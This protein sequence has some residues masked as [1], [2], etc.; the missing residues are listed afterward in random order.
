MLLVGCALAV[1]LA[2]GGLVGD[3]L[4]ER[5]PPRP[6]VVAPALAGTAS[7]ST[8]SAVARL[9]AAVRSEPGNTTLLAQLGLAY[10]QRWRET[11]DAS[12][13]PRSEAAL[14]RAVA[15]R[16]DEPD[17]VLGLGSLA[18]IRHEF[19][20]ALGFGRTAGTL[21]PGSDR[22]Y[23]VVGDALV[24]LGRYDQ[25]F[26][27]FERMAA[28]RP[29]VAS[30]TRV[31]YAREL[32]GDRAGALQAL[33]LALDAA[34]GQREQT[35][36]VLVEIAKLEAPLG[37]PRAA[38]LAV[39]AA[40]L[41]FPGYPSARLQAVKLDLRDGRPA[42]ALAEARRLADAAPSSESVT[43][44]ADLLERVG[45]SAEARRQRATAAVIDRLLRAS[46]VE[47]DLES[48][49]R[50]ADFGIRPAE[51]VELAHRARAARP[52]I[53]GDDALG[54]ALARAGRC[55]EALAYAR[56]SLRL[57]TRDALLFF[58]RGY[59]EGCAG[60]R[61]A[62]R[63]WYRRALALDPAFSVRWAPVARA[64]T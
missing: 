40:L 14:R 59:A 34:A 44:L 53:H 61:S 41:A 48:A 28:L 47:V 2:F 17:A 32:S 60:N 6:R 37:R 18:L 16:P 13:L 8:V 38:R 30:Y 7:G 62:R 24:E 56:R 23:G 29:G 5:T 15:V 55:D 36:F 57:G 27:A 31:A 9:E 63:A 10:Q 25:A 26:A 49:V 46:G 22:P 1:A 11:A 12:Y 21:L 3:V 45:R 43:L 42:R 35:A 19:R 58:H 39:R 54:W 64:G 50:R 20:K 52:S 33:R 4:F 51:T